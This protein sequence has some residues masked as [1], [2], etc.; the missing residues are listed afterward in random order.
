VV[1][2]LKRV[3][4]PNSGLHIFTTVKCDFQHTIC[5]RA[6]LDYDYTTTGQCKTPADADAFWNYYQ[7][8]P[9]PAGIYTCN[10]P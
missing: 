1:A 3:R 4:L 9:C 8:N 5:V 2:F 7:N 6:K 10:V